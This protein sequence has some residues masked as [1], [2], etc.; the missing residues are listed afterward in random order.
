MPASCSACET[1]KSPPGD[2]NR[3]MQ[4]RRDSRRP[5]RVKHLNPRQGITTM[6]SA[7]WLRPDRRT[8]VKHLNPRQGITTGASRCSRVHATPRRRVKHL[9]PRQ[10]ITTR[11]RQREFRHILQRCETPKSPPGDY[12]GVFGVGSGASLITVCETPKSPPGDYNVSYAGPPSAACSDGKCE[13][14]KSPPGDYN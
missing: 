3:C 9:N 6:R 1:P 8:R 4:R 11:G 12:N 5:P 10:G 2:Y 7:L 14:P 13:T